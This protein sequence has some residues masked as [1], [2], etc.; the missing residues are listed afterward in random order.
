M[1]NVRAYKNIELV[2]DPKRFEKLVANPRYEG[3]TIFNENLVAVKMQPTSVCL[4]KPIYVGFFG[5]RPFK[6][7]NV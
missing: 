3:C 6:N 2:T 4:C 5:A 7:A 1:E